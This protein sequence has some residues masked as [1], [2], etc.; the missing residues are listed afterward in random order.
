MAVTEM[1]S[2][3]A[4]FEAEAR[5]KESKMLQKHRQDIEALMQKGSRGRSE[6]ELQ[7]VEETERR[8]QRYRNVMSVGNGPTKSYFQNGMATSTHINKGQVTD[9]PQML[10]RF[11]C[12]HRSRTNGCR[13]N[14]KY[15]EAFLFFYGTLVYAISR[16]NLTHNIAIGLNLHCCNQELQNLQRLE[17]VHLD[18]FLEGQVLAGKR[19]PMKESLFR[20][21]ATIP[22]FWLRS[23][24]WKVPWLVEICCGQGLK[25]SWHLLMATAPDVVYCCA[26]WVMR[27]EDVM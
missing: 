4:A 11:C 2:T 16:L 14:R 26:A 23:N 19:D 3:M 10:A 20:K 7:R 22:T 17:V 1:Q 8:A 12:W 13:G 6:L 25:S 18:N 21:T 24:A 15:V 9:C 5:L 27:E